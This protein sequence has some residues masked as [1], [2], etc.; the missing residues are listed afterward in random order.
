[1]DKADHR[2]LCLP[3][4]TPLGNIGLLVDLDRQPRKQIK[5]LK[6]G[7]GPL[8]YQIQAA[9][10]SSREQ[11]NVDADTEII[12]VILLYRRADSSDYVVIVPR[13]SDAAVE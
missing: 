3:L 11:L 1:M 2:E 9:V 8:T 13:A 7:D 5:R 6:R 4:A 12:P 10:A